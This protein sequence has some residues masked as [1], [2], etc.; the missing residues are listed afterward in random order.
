MLFVT[1]SLVPPVCPL[2]LVPRRLRQH[3]TAQPPC[4]AGAAGAQE[5]GGVEQ[6]CCAAPCFA[7]ARRVGAR[8]CSA[9]SEWVRPV[10]PGRQS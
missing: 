6:A 4:R 10:V 1:V 3:S 5:R 9:R 2:R 7:P 8:V